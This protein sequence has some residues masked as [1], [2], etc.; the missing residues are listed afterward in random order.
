[1][2]KTCPNCGGKKYIQEFDSRGL[3]QYTCRTCNGKGTVPV[4][5]TPEMYKQRTGEEW[6]DNDSVWYLADGGAWVLCEK[7]IAIEW[8]M[9]YIVIDTKSGKPPADYRPED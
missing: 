3:R 6:P 4:Y 8:P 2:N 1:M 5:E 9:K 7:H